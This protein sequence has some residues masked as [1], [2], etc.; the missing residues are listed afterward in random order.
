MMYLAFSKSKSLLGWVI[1]KFTRGTVN[2]AFFLYQEN[3]EWMTY[4]AQFNGLHKATVKDF[5]KNREIVKMFQP[6]GFDLEGGLKAVLGEQGEKESY[7]FDALLGMAGVEIQKR[8]HERIIRNRMDFNKNRVF[9]SE[10]CEEVI[11]RSLLAAKIADEWF[12]SSDSPDTI[13]PEELMESMQKSSLFQEVKVL[14][15]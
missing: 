10:F 15:E 8:L 14:P 13:D 4:G 2:H 9:C 3:G 7:N 5:Q 1:R 12:L 11:Y 6:V